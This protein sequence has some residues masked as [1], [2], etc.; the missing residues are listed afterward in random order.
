M[1]CGE[2][3]EQL[4]A[5]FDG[6]T[7]PA[8]TGEIQ[9]HLDECDACQAL[10]HQRQHL[11]EEL[12]AAFALDRSTAELLGERVCSKIHQDRLPWSERPRRS[13]TSWMQLLAATAAGFLMAMG[14]FRIAPHPAPRPALPQRSA[15]RPQARLTATT[16]RV[17][18]FDPSR[19]E[20]RELRPLTEFTC[21][22]DSALRTSADARCEV[23]TQDGTIVR[24]NDGTEVSFVDADVI[25]LRH[26]Q[27]WC[28]APQRVSLEIRVARGSSSE[29]GAQHLAP[30][31]RCAVGPNSQFSC[32][33]SADEVRFLNSAGDVNV[34]MVNGLRQLAPGESASFANGQVTYNQS[35]A[36]PILSTGWFH[37]LLLQKAADD[38]ELQARVNEMLAQLGQHKLAHLYELEIRTLGGHAAWPLV[39]YVRS[40]LSEQDNTQRMQAMQ[41]AADLAPVWLVPEFI[42]LLEDEQPGVRV[43]AATALRRLTG[44]HMGGEPAQWREPGP[45][46]ASAL[47]DWRQWWEHHQHRFP[48]PALLFDASPY[49]TPEVFPEDTRRAP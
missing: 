5:W 40:S 31:I 23:R 49:Q 27:M 24:L 12:H 17:E 28:R 48:T 45:T 41:L 10:V 16:G 19:R 37:P 2:L 42:E 34:Y 35:A 6:E 1:K 46:N 4:D 11:D 26:G 32:V 47:A 14:V 20:W 30:A 22:Q 3:H 39:R 25:E 43:L 9:T 18:L 29:S 38:A 44:L 36:D 15:V 13:S 21:P 8:A 33:Q 7:D